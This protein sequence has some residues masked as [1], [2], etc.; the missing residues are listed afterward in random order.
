MD[1]QALAVKPA[2]HR[3]RGGGRAKHRHSFNVRR[4]MADAASDGFGLARVLR[5]DDDCGETAERRHRSL[6]PRLRFRGVEASGVALH[7]RGDDRSIGVVGLHEHPPR[8]VGATGSFLSFQRLDMRWYSSL[9][10]Q[11]H[12]VPVAAAARSDRHTAVPEC[13]TASPAARRES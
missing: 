5:R 12:D 1:E 4:G 6:A 13:A 11:P 10:G 3:E 7:E 8:L 2:E 9:I